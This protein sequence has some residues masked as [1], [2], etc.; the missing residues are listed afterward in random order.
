MTA[1]PEAQLAREAEICYATMAH[2]TDYDVWH[3]AEEPVTVEMVIRNL[4]KNIEKAKEILKVLVP[5]IPKERKCACATALKDAIITQR[6]RIPE[7]LKEK[8]K[9]LI[10][11]YLME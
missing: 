7:E 1:V 5:R 9:L 6:E 8:L 11:K 10:G 3:E 4:L 2:V